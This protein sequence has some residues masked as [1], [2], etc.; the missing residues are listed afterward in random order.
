MSNTTRKEPE[1]YYRRYMGNYS[2]YRNN[3]DGTAKAVFHHWDEEIVRKECYRLNG[4]E[5]KPKKNH[6]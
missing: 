6:N 5:Y 1:Y 2:L 4:W 3:H